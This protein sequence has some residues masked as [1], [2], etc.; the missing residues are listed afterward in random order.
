MR[1][2]DYVLIGNA[3]DSVPRTHP[4]SDLDMDF[5]KSIELKEFELYNVVKDPSQQNNLVETNTD[6]LNRMKP[7][8]LK[9]LDEIKND[10][11]YWN[12]LF[13]YESKP[14]KFKQKYIRK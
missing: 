4:I 10:G 1:I 14:S 11:P 9:L 5:I 2:D 12:G 3:L 7:Q 6:V 8:M 13:E